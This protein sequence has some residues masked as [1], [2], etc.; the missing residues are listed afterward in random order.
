MCMC[1]APGLQEGGAEREEGKDGGTRQTERVGEERGWEGRQ[2][3]GGREGTDG[4]REGLSRLEL[5]LAEAWPPGL[6]SFPIKGV[7]NRASC[8]T[9]TGLCEPMAQTCHRLIQKA[10]G[11]E[12]SS[13]RLNKMHTCHFQ[14]TNEKSY[15]YRV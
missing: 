11:L 3:G 9:N 1:P 8:H 6:R 2:Q 4:D 10:G 13:Q 7:P 12:S 14:M 15:N 5:H